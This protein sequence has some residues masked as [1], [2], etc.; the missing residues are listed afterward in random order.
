[1][2]PRNNLVMADDASRTVANLFSTM[3]RWRHLPG[4][5]LEGRLAPFFE[6]FLLDVLGDCLGVEL[7]PIIIPEFP[8]RKGMLFDENGSNQSYNADYVA[9]SDDCSRAFLIELK[10]DMSSINPDQK[11]VLC[12]AQTI[13]LAPIVPGLVKISASKGTRKRMK[14]VHLLHQLSIL[15]LVNIPEQD[16]LYRQTFPTP[17][18]GWTKAFNGVESTLEGK[19]ECTQ[20]IYIQPKIQ[21]NEANLGVRYI[22]FDEVADIVQNFG[23][24]GY[25]FANYLRQWIP[26]AG[27][28]DPRDNV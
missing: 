25:L 17:R 27:E 11:N 28:R 7:H 3:D 21:E 5:R 15:G 10:T 6:L 20:I 2:T 19:L 9:F 16:S 13:G 8:L 18:P 22:D 4:Y 1:M 14:Y 12:K 26:P 23:E 24:V